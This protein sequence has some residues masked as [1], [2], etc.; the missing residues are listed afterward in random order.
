MKDCSK[1]SVIIPV[2]NAE[3]YLTSSINSIINQSYK[4]LEIILVDDGSTDKSPIICDRFAEKDKRVKVIHKENGGASSARNTGLDNASGDYIA[5]IDAD[6][7]IDL[8]MYEIMLNQIIDND[9]DAARCGVVR[10]S[11]DGTTE[12]WGTGN[13]DIQLI[14]NKKLLEDVGEAVGILPVSPCNKLF[15]RSVIGDIRFDTR[16]KFAEDTL[17][18]FMVA[19]NINKMVYNDID[20]YHYIFNED[21]MTNKGIN[22][23]NF[24]EHRV[25]DIIFT[26]ADDDI[27]VHCV[28]GDV[29]KSFRT[30]RQ[31]IESGKYT[32]RFSQIRNRI[33]SHKKEIFTLPIYS[34]LTKLRTLLLLISPAG[35]KFAIRHFRR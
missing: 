32:E 25:M 31:I 19:K 13:H 9:A 10:E 5:F 12:E 4:N 22:E 34:K 14:D 8:D 11:D 33:V 28:K 27:L 15:K 35:Y 26:L 16:F 1:I 6:D 3:N 18:N 30:L 2:Y 24:D 7:Y 23:N 21:S 29:L 17:F 20:R